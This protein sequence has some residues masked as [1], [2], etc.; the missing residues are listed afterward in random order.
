MPFFSIPFYI[1]VLGLW[2]LVLEL[3]G[4][5]RAFAREEY[6]DV[7]KHRDSSIAPQGGCKICATN[8]ETWQKNVAKNVGKMWRKTSTKCGKKLCTAINAEKSFR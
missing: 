2:S 3:K 4:K 8:L 1:L 7:V 6:V 5:S